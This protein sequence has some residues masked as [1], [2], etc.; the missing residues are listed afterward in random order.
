[1]L[2]SS[3]EKVTNG[4]QHSGRIDAVMLLGK[5]TAGVIENL[6][7]KSFHNIGKQTIRIQQIKHIPVDPLIKDK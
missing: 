5:R 3:H 1:M 4:N 6:F 7:L 2:I